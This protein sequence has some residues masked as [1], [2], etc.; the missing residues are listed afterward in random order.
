MLL[1]RVECHLRAPI[2][3]FHSNS[4]PISTI[5]LH[6]PFPLLANDIPSR[7]LNLISNTPR[8]LPIISP[9]LNSGPHHTSCAKSTTA[10]QPTRVIASSPTQSGAK[11]ADGPIT[12]RC[13]PRHSSALLCRSG[14]LPDLQTAMYKGKTRIV[15]RDD[16]NPHHPSTH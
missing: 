2:R 13:R 8:Y 1:L 6:V 11:R 3:S 16:T 14:L 5:L 4:S 15:T 12:Q 9:P 7:Q 10:N